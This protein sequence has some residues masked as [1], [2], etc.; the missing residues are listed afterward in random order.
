MLFDATTVATNDGQ[1]VDLRSHSRIQLVRAIRELGFTG[2]LPVPVDP[3]A[4]SAV[5][6]QIIGLKASVKQEI[7][8]RATKY[9]TADLVE[10][11]T[12]GVERN[13]ISKSFAELRDKLARA[14]QSTDHGPDLFD[15]E[16]LV[17]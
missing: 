4:A 11:V 14:Q 12:A 15:P 2:P 8:R 9:I 13:W 6:D 10:E 7:E 1:P 17:P 16:R 5:R 3:S